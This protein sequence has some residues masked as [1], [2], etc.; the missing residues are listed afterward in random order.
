MQ[1]YDQILNVKQTEY[2]LQELQNSGMQKLS[3][4]DCFIQRSY[5]FITITLQHICIV[6]ACQPM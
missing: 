1:A 6:L 5:M 4:S 2:F 3:Q